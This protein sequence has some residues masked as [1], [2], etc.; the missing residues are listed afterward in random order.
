MK[1]LTVLLNKINPVERH[2]LLFVV[3]FMSCAVIG[4]GLWGAFLCALLVFVAIWPNDKKSHFLQEINF[5][6]LSSTENPSKNNV[7]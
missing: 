5:G 3:L 2:G 7:K 4:A 6:K 1:K